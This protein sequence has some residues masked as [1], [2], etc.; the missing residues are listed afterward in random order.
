MTEEVNANPFSVDA[1]DVA[2]AGLWEPAPYNFR[3]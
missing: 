3:L 1:E 2:K